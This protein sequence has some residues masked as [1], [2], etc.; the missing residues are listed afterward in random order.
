[1][2]IYSPKA[3]KPDNF[4][5]NTLRNSD[6]MISSKSTLK[7]RTVIFE[8]DKE[9]QKKSVTK[10]SLI[11]SMFDYIK[12]KFYNRMK[13]FFDYEDRIKEKTSEAIKKET[14]KLQD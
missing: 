5:K 12:L 13:V 8:I 2:E 4:K 3:K 9:S 10:Q 11:N 1:M 14:F 7:G 6:I